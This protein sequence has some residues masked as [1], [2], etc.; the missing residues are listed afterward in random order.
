MSFHLDADQ[1][2]IVATILR[3]A[4]GIDATSSHDLGMDDLLDE[5]QLIFAGREGRCV[6]TRNGRDF[7]PLTLRFLGEGLPH[8]GVLIVPDSMEN[9][10]FARIARAVAWFNELFPDGA[11]A[12]Y[13]GFLED[14]PDGS[15]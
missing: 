6:V 7:V 15:G 10:E 12:Y 13:V 14:P 11:P 8:A 9:F 2:D 3:T 4:H 5:E 1:S